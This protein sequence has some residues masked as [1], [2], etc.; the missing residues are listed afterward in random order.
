MVIVKLSDQLSITCP[1]YMEITASEESGEIVTYQPTVSGG[2]PPYDIVCAPKSGSKFG[3]AGHSVTCTV[4]DAASN[5]KTCTFFVQVNGK[6][7]KHFV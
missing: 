2:I 3:I 7:H 5:E 1:S 6:F 4:T